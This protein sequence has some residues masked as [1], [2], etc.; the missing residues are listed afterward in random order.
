MP[1]VI[2]GILEDIPNNVNLSM[3]V[4]PKDMATHKL[5]FKDGEYKILSLVPTAVPASEAPTAPTALAAPAAAV[6]ADGGNPHPSRRTM[7]VA[8][9]HPSRRTMMTG[10]VLNDRLSL[11]KRNLITSS[12]LIIC[13]I[14]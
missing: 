7:I 4:T 8:T 13:I 6:P 11:S 9:P 14:P 3:I 10:T 1:S 5:V 2:F 12:T